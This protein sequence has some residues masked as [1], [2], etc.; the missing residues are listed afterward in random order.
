MMWA[1]I[2][3]F[4]RF[5]S[6]VFIKCS[7]SPHKWAPAGPCEEPPSCLDPWNISM[8]RQIWSTF[9]LWFG[10]INK[11]AWLSNMWIVLVL[12]RNSMILLTFGQNLDKRLLLLLFEVSNDLI[13]HDIGLSLYKLQIRR[14]T[15][16]L[17][18]FSWIKCHNNTIAIKVLST[19]FS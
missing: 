12:E 11:V 5:S 13:D 6:P 9:L 3:H 14:E 19:L 7:D 16:L 4:H 18:I 17:V 10:L 8:T 15:M 2:A 1:A